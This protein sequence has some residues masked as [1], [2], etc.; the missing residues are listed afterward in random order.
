MH[1]AA[2]RTISEHAAM[3]LGFQGKKPTAMS[4]FFR[5]AAW[6]VTMLMFFVQPCGAP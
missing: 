3:N 6:C 5:S 4:V 2:T 1:P